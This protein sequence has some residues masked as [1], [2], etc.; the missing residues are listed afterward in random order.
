[1]PK[2]RNPVAKYLGSVN[3]PQ[4][5]VDRKK[6]EKKMGHE[7]SILDYDERPEP[8]PM[9]GSHDT[10]YGTTFLAGAGECDVWDC[11]ECGY[12]WESE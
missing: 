7:E 10:S 12:R 11:Y 6:E 4:T 5:Y 8:C 9:C 3:R 2:R 1:M